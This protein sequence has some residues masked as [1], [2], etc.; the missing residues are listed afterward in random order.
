MRLTKILQWPPNKE[1]LQEHTKLTIAILAIPP[2]SDTDPP[3]GTHI[4]VCLRG[5][6][7]QGILVAGVVAGIVKLATPH[8]LA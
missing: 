4:Y 7:K 5:S 6:S 8:T 1:N 3:T 2:N